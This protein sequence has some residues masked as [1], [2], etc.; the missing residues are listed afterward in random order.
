MGQKL[1]LEVLSW[2]GEAS[3]IDSVF[4]IFSIFR[5][6]GEKS[7]FPISSFTNSFHLRFGMPSPILD[8]VGFPKFHAKRLSKV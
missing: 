1:A 3:K 5:P 4:H 8:S 6:N 7:V 2:T